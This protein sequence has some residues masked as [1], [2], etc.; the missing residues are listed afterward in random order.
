[1]TLLLGTECQAGTGE[2]KMNEEQYKQN[3]HVLH[4]VCGQSK[5]LKKN[6][7][8]SYITVLYSKNLITILIVNL[9][10]S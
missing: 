3:D 9:S 7:L 8:D 6:D 2:S 4:Q 10:F 1:M 5:Y